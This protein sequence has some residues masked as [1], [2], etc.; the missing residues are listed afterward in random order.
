MWHKRTYLQNRNRLTDIENTFLV[1]KGE[2]E[3][4]GWTGSLRLVDEKQLRLLFFFALLFR[5]MPAACGCSQGRS[6]IRAAASGLQHSHSN[7]NTECKHCNLHHSSKQSQILNSLSEARD[8][9]LHPRGYQ[10]GS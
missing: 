5:G 2:G 10:S 9:T 8:Q 1:A 4:V 6:R 7:S 3:E